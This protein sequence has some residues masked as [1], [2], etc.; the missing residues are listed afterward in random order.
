VIDATPLQNEHARRGIGTYVRGLVIGLEARGAPGWGV[1]A[2]PG[3]LPVSPRRSRRAPVVPRWPKALEFHGG[4]VIDQLLLARRLRGVGTFHATD[5]RRIPPPSKVRLIVTVYDL[6]PSHD[7]AVWRS[8]WPDQRLGWHRSVANIRRAHGVIAISHVGARDVV[9]TLGIAPAR[10]HV[11]Y[12]AIAQGSPDPA[13]ARNREPDHLLFVGAPDPHKN[14]DV[15][16]A[17]LSSIPA[18]ARPRLTIVGPWSD[19]A[20]AEVEAD[21]T[22]LGIGNVAVEADVSESRLDVLYRTVTALIVPSRRE[23]FGLPIL[24]AMA[25]GCPIVAADLPVLREVGAD[26]AVYV[27]TNDAGALSDAIVDV[28]RDGSRRSEL[29]A[30]GLRRA[31]DFSPERSTDA[32]LASYRAVGVDL[33]A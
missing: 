27:T 28:L 13:V 10:V 29:G 4:W 26:A 16:L 6:I 1:L 25:R 33:A 20:R 7:R 18:S 21:A 8:M 24:E 14:V 19:R 3:P 17:A 22:R 5:P 32:L 9:E 11:V 2:Y 31:A 12:P 23:G 30:A 15:L